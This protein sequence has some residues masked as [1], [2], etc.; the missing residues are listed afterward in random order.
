[1]QIDIALFK[2][3]V[4]PAFKSKGRDPKGVTQQGYT[5]FI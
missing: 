5:F 1:M 3:R 2:K 4:H